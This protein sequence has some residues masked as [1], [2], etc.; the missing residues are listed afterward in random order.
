MKIIEQ[1]Y[2]EQ[3]F[4]LD[5][6]WYWHYREIINS[7]WMKNIL[8]MITCPLTQRHMSDIDATFVLSRFFSFFGFHFFGETV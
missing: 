2:T 6:D 4:F 7:V 8:I 1:C 5:I 3:D